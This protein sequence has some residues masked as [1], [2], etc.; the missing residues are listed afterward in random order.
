MRTDGR[1]PEQPGHAGRRAARRSSTATSA[2]TL[3]ARRLEHDLARPVGAADD[4]GAGQQ[5]GTARRAAAARARA[6]TAR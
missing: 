5:P 2:A 6:H 1:W 4:L 3:A